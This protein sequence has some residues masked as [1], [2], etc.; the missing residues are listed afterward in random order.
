MI[1]EQPQVNLSFPLAQAKI[2]GGEGG[3]R[4]GGG[5][6]DIQLGHTRLPH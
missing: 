1:K 2:G 4:G 6:L 5:L 3:G